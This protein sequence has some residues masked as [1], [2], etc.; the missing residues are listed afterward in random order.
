LDVYEIEDVLV[1]LRRISVTKRNFIKHL[2]YHTVTSLLKEKEG[3][4]DGS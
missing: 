2:V 1:L 4:K 3:I